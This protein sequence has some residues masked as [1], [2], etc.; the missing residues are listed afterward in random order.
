MSKRDEDGITSL[1]ACL[2]ANLVACRTIRNNS[3]TSWARADFAAF[4]GK[5]LAPL[6]KKE[7]KHELP[8]GFAADLPKVRQTLQHF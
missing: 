8:Y 6:T 1:V 3:K 4:A 5:Y 7:L 2:N